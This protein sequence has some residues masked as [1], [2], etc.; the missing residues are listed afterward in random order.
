MIVC[1]SFLTSRGAKSISHVSYVSLSVSTCLNESR[2]L[3]RKS[4][5]AGNLRCVHWLTSVAA[6]DEKQEK[7]NTFSVRVAHR[8]LL[9]SADTLYESI[10]GK[11]VDLNSE[12]HRKKVARFAARRKHTLQSY[13]LVCW[14]KVWNFILVEELHRLCRRECFICARCSQKVLVFYSWNLR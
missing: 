7:K 9:R 14:A 8:V 13:A 2:R 10:S 5:R 3:L 11:R 12:Q 1:F 6:T 4:R